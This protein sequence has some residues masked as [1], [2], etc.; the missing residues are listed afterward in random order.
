MM[1]EAVGSRSKPVYR[2]WGPIVQDP[3]IDQYLVALNGCSKRSNHLQQLAPNL[4]WPPSPSPV[5]HTRGLLQ[6]L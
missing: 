4:G 5:P 1:L 3:Y 6:I 2:Q